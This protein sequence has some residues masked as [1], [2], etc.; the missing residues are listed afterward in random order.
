MAIQ[1]TFNIDSA[2]IGST[3]EDVFKSL[4]ADD[5]RELARGIMMEVLTTPNNAER[6][7]FEQQVVE[8]LI[9][10]YENASYPSDRIRT[11]S[12]ARCS[13]RFR[14]RM[15]K[16][17]S[18]RD[19]MMRM[20]VEETTKLYKDMV[21]ELVKNDEQ[22]QAVLADA[23]ASFIK[24]FPLLC[25]QAMNSFFVSRMSEIAIAMNTSFMQQTNMRMFSDDVRNALAAHGIAVP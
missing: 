2:N 22:T 23:Q 16:F 11:E 9:R 8:Q 6:L 1:I 13:H 14:E 21:A 24:A 20:I 18:S 25:Q 17:E 5:K 10:E 3:V 15:T 7:A 19:R 12:E 4:T